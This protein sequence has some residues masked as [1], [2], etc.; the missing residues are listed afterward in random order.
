RRTPTGPS[1]WATW[2]S[3]G[4][5]A[6]SR[7]P[8]PPGRTAGPPSDDAPHSDAWHDVRVSAPL[9]PPPP[10]HEHSAPG[11]GRSTADPAVDGAKPAR[12]GPAGDGRYGQHGHGM[13]TELR[14]AAGA[15]VA[16][17]RGGVLL[18]GLWWRLAPR[19]PLVGDA[20]DGNWVVFV[21]ETEGEQAI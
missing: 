11:A 5:S 12:T 13:T 10:P 1:C 14:E 4:S 16:V 2:R 9:T 8:S 7:W 15:A 17:A 6:S 18:G 21:K 3:A 19:G 20:V